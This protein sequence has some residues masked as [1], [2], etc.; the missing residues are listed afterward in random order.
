MKAVFR[1][2][3]SEENNNGPTG[4][5]PRFCIRCTGWATKGGADCSEKEETAGPQPAQRE[6][7]LA[8]TPVFILSVIRGPKP[9]ICTSELEI[10]LEYRSNGILRGVPGL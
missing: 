1:G 3:S 8:T 6:G 5:Q 4:V 7:A 9:F 10:N 2:F